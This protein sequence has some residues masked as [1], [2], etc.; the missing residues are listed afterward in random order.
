MTDDMRI[1]S[2]SITKDFYKKHLLQKY[3]SFL[4]NLSKDAM[5]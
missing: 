3:T 5:K 2:N 4:K 1:E